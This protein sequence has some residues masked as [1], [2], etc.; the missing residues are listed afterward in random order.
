MTIYFGKHAGKELESLPSYYLC[1]LIEDCE[2]TEQLVREA[3]K[4]ELVRRLSLDWG[5][6]KDKE[7]VSHLEKELSEASKLAVF[8]C[9][10]LRLCRFNS[11]I[12]QKYFANPELLDA[13]IESITFNA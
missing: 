10:V 3:S 9:K 13:D 1:F 5:T 2:W 8:Y 6:I 11:L 4:K 7:Y 12:A